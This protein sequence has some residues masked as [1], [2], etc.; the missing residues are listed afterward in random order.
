MRKLTLLL[1][2]LLMAWPAALAEPD[3]FAPDATGEYIWPEGA[4]EAEAVYVWRAAYPQLAEES[5]TAALINGTFRYLITDA[6]GFDCPMNASSM[7]LDGPQ[8]RIDIRYRV[9]YR[10][11]DSLSLCVIKDVTYDGSTETFLT[12]YTFPLTGEQPGV[13]VALPVLLGI[14]DPASTDE[15]YVNR[16]TEKVDKCVRGLVWEALLEMDIPLY[17]DMDEESF[18]WYFYPESDYYLDETGNLVFFLQD[19]SVSP[20]AE[21]ILV[22]IDMDVLLDEL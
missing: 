14:L 13:A 9:T 19:R 1:L 11:E 22:P 18:E 17:E 7:P 10:S 3:F 21:P 2:A 6:L 16:Q 5:E 8:M 12:G 20:Q 4:T 15:W